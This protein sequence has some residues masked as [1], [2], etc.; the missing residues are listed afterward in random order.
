MAKKITLADNDNHVCVTRKEI[1]AELDNPTTEGR[2]KMEEITCTKCKA[3]MKIL[4]ENR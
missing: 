2:K 3:L 1:I 4:Q